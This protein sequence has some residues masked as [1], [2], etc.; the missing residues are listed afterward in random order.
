MKKFCILLICVLMFTTLSLSAFAQDD[1]GSDPFAD[2]TAEDEVIT[3]NDTA[4]DSTEPTDDYTDTDDSVQQEEQYYYEETDSKISVPDGITVVLDGKIVVFGSAQPKAVNGRTLVP[5]RKFF[6]AFGADVTWNQSTQTAKAVK[7]DMS[8]EISIGSKTMYCGGE[9][10]SL[11]VPA[12]VFYGSTYVPVRF[13]SNALGAKV[14]WD[15]YKKIVS[16]NTDN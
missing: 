7:G 1:P 15:G 9:A 6:E 4:A 5:M 10:V 8:V 11:D 3:Q 16:V 13:I 12:Q 2:D 14:E